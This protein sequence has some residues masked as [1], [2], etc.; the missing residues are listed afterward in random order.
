MG[1][2]VLV[3]DFI[4]AGRRLIDALDRDGFDVNTALWF[5]TAEDQRWELVIASKD[6]QKKGLI[7]SYTRVGRVFRAIPDI[8][9]LRDGLDLDDVILTK[10]S[11]ELIRAL[12]SR[13][14]VAPGEREI[15]L[16]GT[17][18]RGIPVDDAIL[19]RVQ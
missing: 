14:H 4:A 6:V 3:T 8:D 10:P 17:F 13:Y 2:V 9:A 1:Q 11:D 15:R 19:Y 16:T 7:D 5:Y 18:V 12:R